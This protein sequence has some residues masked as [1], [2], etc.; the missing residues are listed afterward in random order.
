IFNTGTLAASA[1]TLNGSTKVNSISRST[2]NVSIPVLTSLDLTDPTVTSR[3][4]TLQ[5]QSR[6][7][8]SLTVVGGVATG[9][10]VILTPLNLRSGLTGFNIPAGVTV[11]NSNFTAANTISIALTASSYTSQA[12]IG[13]TEQF[14]GTSTPSSGIITITSTN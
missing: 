9:G 5:S 11:T 10:N 2:F 1:I 13:G 7:G 12:I 3:I 6:L 4:V 8:G 14:I